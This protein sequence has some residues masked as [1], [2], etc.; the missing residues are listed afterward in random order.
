MFGRQFHEIRRRFHVRQ[1]LGKAEGGLG[2]CLSKF[3][4]LVVIVL[5]AF[6]SCGIAV[7]DES[8]SFTRGGTHLFES[9]FSLRGTVSRE[10]LSSIPPRGPGVRMWCIRH[11]NSSK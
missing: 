11:R 2:I 7:L 8:G 5:R 10:R 3:E 6:N 9:F 4:N 1:L